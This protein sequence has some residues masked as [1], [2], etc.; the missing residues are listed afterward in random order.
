[1]AAFLW[2]KAS[3]DLLVLI[4]AAI[5]IV[6]IFLGEKWFLKNKNEE[7]QMKMNEKL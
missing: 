1:L 7:N 2:I 5:L 6:L 4:V 3:S